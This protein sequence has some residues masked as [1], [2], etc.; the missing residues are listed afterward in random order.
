MEKSGWLDDQAETVA[1]ILPQEVTDGKTTID[2]FAGLETKNAT[3]QWQKEHGLFPD[4]IAGEAA[5][6]RIQEQTENKETDW[7]RN[8]R[9]FSRKDVE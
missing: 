8:I 9:F 6:K 2:G 7:R 3:V 4:A 5:R 1:A